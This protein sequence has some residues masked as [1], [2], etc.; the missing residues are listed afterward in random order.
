MKNLT[1]LFTR[2]AYL[3]AFLL[4]TGFAEVNAQGTPPD[5]GGPTPTPLPA[6]IPI[7]GGASLLLAGG[8]AY[9][10]NKLRSRRLAK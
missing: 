10:L 5:D 6:E 1:K 4:L 2:I 8:L 7:D 9:G 3:T